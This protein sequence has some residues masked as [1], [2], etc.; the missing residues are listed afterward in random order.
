MKRMTLISFVCLLVTRVS[1]QDASSLYPDG[2]LKHWQPRYAENLRWNFENVVRPM[3]RSSERLN[4]AEVQLHFP[5]KAEREVGLFAFY[6]TP[7]ADPPVVA[8]PVL[9]IKFFDD[10]CVANAWLEEND[11][12][13]G[14]VTDYVAMLKYLPS[15]SF[16]G[17]RYLPP[18]AALQIP[19]NALDNP[20]VDSLSQKLLKSGLLWVLIH[21]LAHVRYKHPG[22]D[23]VSA[24][25]AQQQETEADRFATEIMRRIGVA[26]VG[27][28]QF[29]T[30]ATY[31][32]PNRA[33]F[34]SDVAWQI[35]LENTPHPLTT[36]RLRTLTTDL[37]AN[38]E[39]FAR[40]EPNPEAVR[41]V[42][43][44]M[45]GLA[46]ILAEEDMQRYIKKRALDVAGQ[47]DPLRPRP[48]EK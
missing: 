8:M 31:L 35:Y 28:A 11:Y 7:Q 29:F 42:I 37:R 48:K 38:L 16:P 3:L 1:A 22:Y 19:A 30:I 14:T 23:E 43:S 10:L 5:L 41:T 2:T 12:E 34:T 26:P 20:R 13:L 39:S 27:V 46:P 36:A 18:L 44:S 6:S 45:E 25:Q 33:D 15:G 4:L 17:G 9:S 47:P 24:D 21:E 40:G 32:W